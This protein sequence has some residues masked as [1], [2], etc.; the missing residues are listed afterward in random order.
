MLYPTKEGV[1]ERGMNMRI[2]DHFNYFCLMLSQYKD[3]LDTI[4]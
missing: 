3:I 4:T 1:L 2:E